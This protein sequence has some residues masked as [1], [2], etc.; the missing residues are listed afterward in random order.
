MLPITVYIAL[1][2]NLNQPLLQ[3]QAALDVLSSHYALSFEQHS[4]LYQTPALVKPGAAAQP[5][6]INAVVRI[7]TNLEPLALLEVC[8]EIE[9]QFG[10][11]RSASLAWQP[12]TLDLDI[13]LIEG[14]TVVLPNLTIPHP[15][16]HRRLFVL[17]PLMDVVQMPY[18]RVVAQLLRQVQKTQVP[19]KVLPSAI[20]K[21][22][23]IV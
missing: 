11:R 16:M 5:D 7:S 6:Y 8:R 17:Q 18:A 12:R 23:Q 15:E 20:V 1:G 21:P 14:K 9:I 3:I 22:C 4:R 13:L 19:L 10:R 2:S